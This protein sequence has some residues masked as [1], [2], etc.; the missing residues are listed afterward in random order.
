MQID[1]TG[2]G[3]SITEGLKVHTQDKFLKIKNHFDHKIMRVHVTYT[4]QKNEQIAEASVAIGG[5]EIHAK[6]S[7]TDMYSAIDDMIHKLDKQLI[8]H[9]EKITSHRVEKLIDT[10]SDINSD[11]SM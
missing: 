9:K 1:F 4:V 11:E 6:S 7:H 10:D 3:M 5:K 2:H 8:K